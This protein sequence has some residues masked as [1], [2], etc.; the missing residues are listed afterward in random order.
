MDDYAFTVVLNYIVLSA[1]SV[2]CG[3]VVNTQQIFLTFLDHTE[4]TKYSDS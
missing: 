2:L 4:N 1:K 3:S